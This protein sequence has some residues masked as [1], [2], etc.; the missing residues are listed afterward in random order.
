MAV[1]AI[2][3]AAV[4]DL[5]RFIEEEGASFPA[6][7]LVWQV[8]RA[9]GKLLAEGDGFSWGLLPLLVCEAAGG[10]P[11]P[12][13][14]LSTAAEC[15][16]S[17]ADTLDDV[18]DRD[19][20]DGLWRT[21]G[22]ATATNVSALLFFLAQLAL[23]RLATLGMSDGRA[24]EVIHAFAA[25]GARGCGGQQVDLGQGMAR[26]IDEAE[27]LAMIEAK[28]ASLVECLCRS[29]AI[30]AGAQPAEIEV[31]ARF[32]LSVGMAL[33]LANDIAA[34]S[35][36]RADRNDLRLGKLSL[37]ML[38]ALER[39][40]EPLGDELAGLLRRGRRGR[41]RPG[42]VGQVRRLLAASGAL[43]YAVAIVDVYWERALSYL[44]RIESGRTSHLRDLVARMRGS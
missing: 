19:T 34:A 16:I 33:Q 35:A 22:V 28:S 1:G 40:P 25:A 2:R 43:H 18:Q 20:R 21:C 3:Q 29:G 6:I 31:F 11:R 4:A 36:E 17:A 38:F 7:D 24:L 9:Q 23:G 5:R 10:D 37:P 32:G 14:P 8:L 13:L 26:D 39:G 42:D 30:V 12:A 44:D 27:Y 41:L 15:F